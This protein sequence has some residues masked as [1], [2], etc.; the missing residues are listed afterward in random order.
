MDGWNKQEVG[1]HKK[2]CKSLETKG[3]LIKNLHSVMIQNDPECCRRCSAFFGYSNQNIKLM[4]FP[5]V[6]DKNGYFLVQ[7]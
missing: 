2:N 3:F 4:D 6:F 7:L 1:W 5:Q